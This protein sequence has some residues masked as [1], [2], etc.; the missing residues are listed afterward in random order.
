MIDRACALRLRWRL[1]GKLSSL[2]RVPELPMPCRLCLLSLAFLISLAN[3][4]CLGQEE[5]VLGKKRSEWLVILKSHKEPKLRRAAVI[6]LGAIG[7]RA[8][9]VLDGLYE[10]VAG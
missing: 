3:A 9:G 7:P 5:E 8:A 6:A 4:V 2:P 1:Q 10:A